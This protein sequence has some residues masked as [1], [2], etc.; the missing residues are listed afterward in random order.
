MKQIHLCDCDRCKR[1]FKRKDIRRMLE[2]EYNTREFQDS[3][4]GSDNFIRFD[5]Q[6][7]IVLAINNIFYERLGD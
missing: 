2:H 4:F 3:L 6:D 5:S 1:Y 7:Y